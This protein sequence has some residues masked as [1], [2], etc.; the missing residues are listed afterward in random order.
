MTSAIILDGKTLSDKTVL[1]LKPKVASFKTT[2]K[3]SVILVGSDPASATYVGRKEKACGA[4]GIISEVIRLSESTTQAQLLSEIKRLNDDPSVNGILC[5]VPLPKQIDEKTILSAISPDKDVD[6]FHPTN[7]GYLFEGHPKVLPCTPGGIM[8]L[9]KAYNLSVEG[10]HAVI[11]GRS[12]IVGKPM[13]HLLLQAN[14]TVTICH[15]KTKDLSEMV[16]QA[17]IVVAAIGKP[18]MVLGSWIK[19]GAV[20]IDV[21][22][23]RIEDKS[24]ASGFRLVGDVHYES[25]LEKASS[26]TPVPGGVGPMTIATLMENVLRLASLHQK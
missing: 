23:N 24:K 17:D 10:K 3:L 19:R 20:V 11:L 4:A 5:Q 14:A 15:S 13:A 7:V 2:P 12:N 9:L 26:I 21:G 18:E 25:V 8:T 6:C 1:A 16:K 22:I